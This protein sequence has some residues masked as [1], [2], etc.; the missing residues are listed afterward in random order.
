MS[1]RTHCITW[2]DYD[3][4]PQVELQHGIRFDTNYYYWPGSWIQDRPGLFTGSGFPQRF[5]TAGGDT[6]DVYQAT[7]QM[8]DE[9]DQT[10]PKTINTLLDNALGPL[11]YYGAFTANIHTDTAQPAQWAAIVSAAQSRGVPLVSARQMLTW[12]D[13]R[14]AS[15]FGNVSFAGNVL[16]FTLNAGAGA[17]GLQ[18]ML[19]AKSASGATLTALTRNSTSVPFT[20][21]TR[22]GID[23]VVFDA[24]SGT[25]SA[26]YT[27]DTTPPVISAVTA[28]PTTG[29]ATIAWTTDEPADSKVM[30]GTAPGSLTT[31]LD[32]QR[33][34]DRRTRGRSPGSRRA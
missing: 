13:G 19:P 33:A 5:A 10:Y 18:A 28:S 12:L 32:R 15:S 26:T 11:G 3:T 14:N 34:R 9:S 6:I 16:G 20:T 30:Y 2:S 21:V 7:T 31:V 22:K 1:N 23:Y 29:G 25:Y 4:Q 27:A 8:T 17:N 24:A